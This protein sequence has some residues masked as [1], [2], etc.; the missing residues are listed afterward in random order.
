METS[1]PPPISDCAPSGVL[2]HVGESRLDLVGAQMRLCPF[3]CFFAADLGLW[4]RKGGK[5]PRPA[6]AKEQKFRMGTFA[7]PPLPRLNGWRQATAEAISRLETPALKTPLPISACAAQER[8]RWQL[9]GSTGI[10]MTFGMKT[11]YPYRR[12]FRPMPLAG[13]KPPNTRRSAESRVEALSRF[14]SLPPAEK[15]RRPFQRH[16]S[17]FRDGGNGI[18]RARAGK[19]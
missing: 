5:P 7:P 10:S 18:P 13:G 6:N 12:R 14:G 15:G 17:G 2:D 11:S 4:H 19:S 9:A 3:Q 1:Q 16:A 8:G